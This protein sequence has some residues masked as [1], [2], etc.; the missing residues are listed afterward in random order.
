MVLTALLIGLG[1]SGALVLGGVLG[2]FYKPPQK[3][4]A[5][6]LAFASGAL[7]TAVAF[8]MFRDAVDIAG[9]LLAG[10]GIMAGAVIFVG[11]TQLVNRYGGPAAPAVGATVDGTPES[12]ALGATLVGNTTVGILSLVVSIFISN[13]PESLSGSVDMKRRS[14]SKNFIV[15]AW[16]VVALVLAAIVFL[17]NFFLVGLDETTIAF[18]QAL[19]GGAVLASL[20]SNI[21]PQ[22]YRSG[23]LFVAL[24]TPAGFLLAFWLAQL[25]L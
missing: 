17:S 25:Q 16:I 10:V 1:V 18:I 23:G 5:A 11:A 19:A 4:V 9:I 7:I 6:A 3:L 12:L 24:A 22:A 8:D 13:L 15:G 2:A 21:M 20:A 14:R